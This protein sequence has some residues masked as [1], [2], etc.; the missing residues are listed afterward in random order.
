L[1][2][3]VT[4]GLPAFREAAALWFRVGCLSFGGPA[5]QIALMHRLIVEERRWISDAR[6]LHALNYCMLLPGPEAQQLATYIGWLMHGLKG[7]IVAG[8]LFI[9]PGAL[10]MLALSVVYFLYADVPAI[11]AVLFGLKA[12]VLAIVLEAVMRIGRRTLTSA[13]LGVIAACAFAGLFFFNLPFPLIILSAGIAGLL[14]GIYGPL[15]AAQSAAD[16]K[17]LDGLIDRLMTEGR[18]PHTN[19]NSR[20]TVAIAM[21][22]L[23]AWAAPIAFAFMATPEGSIWREQSVLFSKAALVTFGGAY[24]V[25]PY[26]AQQAVE[27]YAWLGPQEMIHGLA[28]A[29]TTPGPLIL[30]LQFVGFLSAAREAGGLHPLL[31]GTLGAALTLWVTFAPSFLWIFVGAPYAEA[32]RNIRALQFALKAITAAVLGVVLNLAIWFALHVLFTSVGETAHGPIRLYVPQFDTLDIGALALSL[33][34]ATALL[35]A[36]LGVVPVLALSAALGAFL[37]IIEP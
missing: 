30:V 28:L 6:F 24:A 32:I 1:A 27:T 5:G 37:K 20:K 22:S 19:R 15:G 23:G 17:N 2:A 16:A 34:A 26:V 18:L 29:E 3:A 12:A 13:W 31:A 9:L 33:I 11:Q 4:D 36:K 21:A 35:R 14:A 7:G 10:V 8:L 25:L